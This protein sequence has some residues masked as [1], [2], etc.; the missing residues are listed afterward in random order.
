MTEFIKR[1]FGFKSSKEKKSDFSAF[2]HDASAEEQKEVLMRVIKK[3]NED[4]RKVIEKYD[5]QMTHV[6]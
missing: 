1:F 2:F 3:A 4:Q 6:R 5:K